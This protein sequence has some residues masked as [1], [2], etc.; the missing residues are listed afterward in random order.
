MCKSLKSS[1]LAI[2]ILLLALSISAC[3]SRYVMRHKEV[4]KVPELKQDIPYTVFW[5]KL[6]QVL[7]LSEPGL[8]HD[9]YFENDDDPMVGIAD[10]KNPERLMVIV[11]KK[12]ELDKAKA[13]V[14]SRSGKHFYPVDGSAVF[15]QDG[16]FVPKLNWDGIT[17]LS[18]S[19]IQIWEEIRPESEKDEE[20]KEILQAAGKSLD[21]LKVPGLLDR[22]MA[23]VAKITTDDVIL[24]GAT[25][26]HS[27]FGLFGVRL[28]ALVE[29]FIQKADLS[30]P[31]YDTALV[32]R[33]QLSISLRPFQE[34]L[35]N[36][37][38]EQK[39]ALAKWLRKI[40]DYE[41]RENQYEADRKDWLQKI[42]QEQGN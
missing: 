6:N 16:F 32:D 19:K 2:G 25:D 35:N 22:V 13:V 29:A 14:I 30:L 4:S 10:P 37:T 40:E 5:C 11:H 23:R 7:L 3:G 15:S 24:A 1:L 38:Q 27:L 34:Q 9:L 31:Y 20:V 12:V 42:K 36:L 39:Q 33:F 41:Q 8:R 26:F 18:K 28:W 17:P 21:Q